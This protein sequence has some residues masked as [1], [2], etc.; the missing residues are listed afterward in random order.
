M[1]NAKLEDCTPTPR[2]NASTTVV[3]AVKYTGLSKSKVYQMMD[4][5][6]LPYI[7]FGRA[8]RIR[9]SDLDALIES[10]LVGTPIVNFQDA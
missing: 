2:K 8:R 1:V 5:G 7:R 3:E 9:W 10:R 6:E 4:A